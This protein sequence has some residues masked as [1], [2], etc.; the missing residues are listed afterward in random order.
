LSI[1][2]CSNL[3]LCFDDF[4]KQEILSGE[5]IHDTGNAA[6]GKQV[7]NG[8]SFCVVKLIG[9]SEKLEI[10]LISACFTHPLEEIYCFNEQVGKA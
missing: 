9:G 5:N 2:G 1:E 3:S 7:D 10:R 4:C 6:F 8:F